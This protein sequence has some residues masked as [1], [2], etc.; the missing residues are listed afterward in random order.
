[1][2]AVDDARRTAVSAEVTTT[3]RVETGMGILEFADGYPT[4]ET[5][6]KLPDHLDYLHSPQTGPAPRPATAP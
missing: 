1:M 5:A 4:R 3:D 2:T 6:A